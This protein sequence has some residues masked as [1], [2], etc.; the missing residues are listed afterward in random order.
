MIAERKD[1]LEILISDLILK[2]GK[3]NQ[4]IHLL[5]SRIVELELHLKKQSQNEQKL[6]A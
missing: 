3:A 4:Q 2:L 5:T 1:S 6:S